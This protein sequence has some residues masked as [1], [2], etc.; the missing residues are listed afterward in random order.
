MN[1][2]AERVNLSSMAVNNLTP[3]PLQTI[4]EEFF[5]PEEAYKQYGQQFQQMGLTIGKK[6]RIVKELGLPSISGGVDITRYKVINDTGGTID[7]PIQH[8][9]ATS[10]GGQLDETNTSLG[11]L[12]E[13]P[14]SYGGE[15]VRGPGGMPVLRS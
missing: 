6:Y 10:M 15:D 9:T 8:F 5:E 1:I 2:P 4:R 11:S 7:V 12:P 3:T 14:L 13:I